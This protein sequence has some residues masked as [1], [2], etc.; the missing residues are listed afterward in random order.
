MI[1]SPAFI[2]CTDPIFLDTETTGLETPEILEIAA[3]PLD[4]PLTLL[5]IRPKSPIEPEAQAVHGLTLDQLGESTFEDCIHKIERCL[6]NRVV[7]TW[8]DFDLWAMTYTAYLW[9][10]RNPAYGSVWIDGMRVYMAAMGLD[11]RI[12]LSDAAAELGV[13]PEPAH[14]AL[15]DAL[16]LR[17]IFQALARGRSTS[18]QR[19]GGA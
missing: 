9:H 15:G 3:V 13:A 18:D 8:G 5:R 7:V 4:G 10:Q 1:L 12:K 2:L 14:T 17:A 11:R 6:D 16:T 19:G